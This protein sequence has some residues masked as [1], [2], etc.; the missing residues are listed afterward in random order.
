MLVLRLPRQAPGDRAHAALSNSASHSCSR[1]GGA[2]FASPNTT[3][4]LGGERRGAPDALVWTRIDANLFSE[5][6]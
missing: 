5:P 4:A 3:A 1:D 6:F 2:A